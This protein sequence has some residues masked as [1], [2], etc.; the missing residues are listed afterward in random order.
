[1][2]FLNWIKVNPA[3]PA[4]LESSGNM[5]R[6]LGI[7]GLKKILEKTKW[8]LDKTIE[9]NPCYLIFILKREK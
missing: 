8:T 4:L 6:F 9:G 7:E 3:F 2:L 1:M 5:V